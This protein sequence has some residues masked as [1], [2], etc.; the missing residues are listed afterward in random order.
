MGTTEQKLIELFLM[1]KKHLGDNT[2][3]SD[4]VQYIIDATKER[5]QYESQ[6]SPKETSVH[7]C[8]G[9]CH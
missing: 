1:V 4:L 5:I 7:K 6:E 9:N 3:S 8:C 2:H